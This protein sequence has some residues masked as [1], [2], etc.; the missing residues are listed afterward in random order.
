MLEVNATI[1][2]DNRARSLQRQRTCIVGCRLDNQRASTLIEVFNGIRLLIVTNGVTALQKYRQLLIAMLRCL[3]F[4][5]FGIVEDERV[6]SVKHDALIA[7]A[8]DM[9]TVGLRH[10]HTVDIQVIAGRNGQVEGKL[11]VIHTT[12]QHFAFIPVFDIKFHDERH[13]AGTDNG[14]LARLAVNSGDVI[15]AS[16]SRC[17]FRRIAHRDTV[18]V[19]NGGQQ[20]GCSHRCRLTVNG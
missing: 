18:A 5:Q 7:L 6:P 14:Y 1:V 10:L 15:K 8:K 12:V 2:A 11:R 3:Y 4:V 9:L 20:R 17:L 19:L 13:R 16:F